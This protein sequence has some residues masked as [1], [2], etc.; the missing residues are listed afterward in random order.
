MFYFF[1]EIYVMGN[2]IKKSLGNIFG[3]RNSSYLINKRMYLKE[4][5]NLSE[6]QYNVILI[7]S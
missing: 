7:I 6:I 4:I 3:K 2:C 1:Y 5:I